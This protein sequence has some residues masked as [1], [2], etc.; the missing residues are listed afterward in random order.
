MNELKEQLHVLQTRFLR[1]WGLVAIADKEKQIAALQQEMTAEGFWNNQEKAKKI[2]QQ[3]SDLESLVAAWKHFKKEIEDTADILD[4][5][6]KDHEVSLHDDLAK[7]LLQLEKEFAQLELDLLF[8]G[9]YDHLPAIVTIHVGSGGTDAQDWTEM[10][11]RMYLRFC[12]KQGWKTEIISISAGQEAGIKSVQFEVHGHNA[13]GY[14]KSEHGVHRLVRISPFDAEKLR[15]TSFAMVEVMPLIDEDTTVE[16]DPDDLRIDTFRAGGHG[17]QSVNTT[18][19]A[20]RITH[21]PT[22]I[23]AQC[24]NERSQ[25]QNKDRAMKVLLSKL[26]QYFD[27]EREEERQRLRGEYTE[28]AWGNQVRSY[29]LHPYQLVKDHRTHFETD[30]VND[31]LDGDIMAFIEAYLRSQVSV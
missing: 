24:Q 14:L 26:Q 16:I 13:F 12:E 29:V 27:A 17:G 20:V 5:D 1:A 31:V 22:G 21:M 23:V 2:S 19:S 30:R 7:Q 10:L 11:L 8:T 4:M 9:K 3:A 15:H 18:D 6:I 25:V 28:A